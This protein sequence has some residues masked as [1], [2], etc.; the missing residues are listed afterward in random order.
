MLQRSK[1]SAS[2]ATRLDLL[3]ALLE[4]LDYFFKVVW[5]GIL[6]LLGGLGWL[7]WDGVGLRQSLFKLLAAFGD[8][9]NGGRQ[10]VRHLVTLLVVANS[11]SCPLLDVGAVSFDCLRKPYGGFK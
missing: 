8:S 3:S 2:S 4:S 5:H 10:F 7:G 9:L 6:F 11:L 1:T